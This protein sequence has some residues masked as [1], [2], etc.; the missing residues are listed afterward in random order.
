M[1]GV[2]RLFRSEEPACRRAC[3]GF[4]RRDPRIKSDL[5]SIPTEIHDDIR[6]ED[7]YTWE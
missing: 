4:N 6:L 5:E 1:P 7:L 2:L 3:P